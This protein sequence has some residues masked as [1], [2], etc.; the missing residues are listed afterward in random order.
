[1]IIFYYI[2]TSSHVKF[3]FGPKWVI[4]GLLVH[5]IYKYLWAEVLFCFLF[6]LLF[7]FYLVIYFIIIIFYCL[8][9]FCGMVDCGKGIKHRS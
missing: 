9:G 8:L 5:G 1:M 2:S 4:M 7:Y 3:L 6:L